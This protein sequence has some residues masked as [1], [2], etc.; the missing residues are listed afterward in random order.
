MSSRPE[1]PACAGMTN[2][3]FTRFA[4]IDWSGAKGKRHKGIAVAVAETGTASPRLVRPDQIW[5]RTEVLEWLLAEAAAAPTLFG[6]DFSFAPPHR[7]ARRIS[8]GREGRPVHGEG[9]LGLCR[10]PERG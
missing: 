4:A 9:I 3:R 8:S 1:V 2:G 6:F 10:Q 5:S 7:R